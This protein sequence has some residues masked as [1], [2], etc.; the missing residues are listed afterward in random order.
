V[1]EELSRIL[2]QHEFRDFADQDSRTLREL[3]ERFFK[4]LDG[5]AAD[6]QRKTQP[7]SF[8]LPPISP[9]LLMGLCVVVLCLIGM[10]VSSTRK[11]Q[12]APPA[13]DEPPPA[14]DEHEPASLLDE[15]ARLAAAG[16]A[17]GALRALYLATLSALER[18][19]LIEYEPSKT[20]WQYTRSLPRG[21]LRQLFAAFTAI[22][23]R[24]WYGHESATHGDYEQCRQLAARICGAERA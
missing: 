12:T 7:S 8:K 21:E 4:W 6:R 13:A 17:R 1:H 24:K 11:P 9:W 15:A 22:F 23:D 16:D 10:Y 19:H 3:L 18:A 5:L 2:E 14:P 20:N